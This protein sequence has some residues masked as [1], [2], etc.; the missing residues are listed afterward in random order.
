MEV[1]YYNSDLDVAVL[2]VDGADCSFLRLTRAAS[3]CASRRRCSATPTTARTTSRRPGSAGSAAAQPRH[4]RRRHGGARGLRSAPWVQPGNPAARCSPRTA[5][6]SRRDLRGLGDRPRH[7]LRA[8]RRLAGA[9]ARPRASPTASRSTPATAP[10]GLVPAGRREPAHVVEGVGRLLVRE[11]ADAGEGVGL[12]G[13][14]DLP[15]RA[16][17]ATA[18]QRRVVGAVH[19]AHRLRH[20]ALHV[21][22]ELPAVAAEARAEQPPVVLQRAVR[23]GPQ[24][25]G[26]LAGVA[27]VSSSGTST[28]GCSSSRGGCGGTPS[29]AGEPALRQGRHL[30][31]EQV[32]Q[33]HRV[34]RAEAGEH[35]VG[36]RRGDGAE[37]GHP[38]RGCSAA[39]A[40]ATYPPQP[41]RRAPHCARR[42]P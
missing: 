38:S 4:L 8:H 12:V 40:Q 14:G 33:G 26:C 11:V 28:T 17:G 3:W 6:C 1:V 2:S 31:R 16:V 24:P 36:V 37:R 25:Q 9:A 13:P 10:E 27:T 20:G 21:P 15:L 35:H 18:G 19:H 41:G 30:H 42:A 29:S 22:V 7:R 39:A 34:A 32:P 23:R 5:P